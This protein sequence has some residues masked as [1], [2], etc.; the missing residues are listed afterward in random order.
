MNIV[1]LSL[2]WVLYGLIHSIFAS[3]RVKRNI[4]STFSIEDQTYRKMYVIQSIVFLLPLWI[5]KRSFEY[6]SLYDTVWTK[7]IGIFLSLLGIFI[8]FKTLRIYR[9]RSFVGIDKEQSGVLIQEGILSVVRHPLY[10]GTI[11][12]FLGW[13]LFTGNVFALVST[14]W[15]CMYLIPGIYWEEKKL[16]AEFGEKYRKYKSKVPSI[17]PRIFT[18]LELLKLSFTKRK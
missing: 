3:G 15:I 10:L 17:I 14:I 6:T 9:V 12:I 18:I 16:E 5:L 8:F 7:V 13:S 11:L 2:F 1:F 4:Q